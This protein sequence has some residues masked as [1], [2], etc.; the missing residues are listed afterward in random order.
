MA[1]NAMVS[2]KY[3]TSGLTDCISLISG[4]DLC[5]AIKINHFLA[6]LCGVVLY[7]FIVFKNLILNRKE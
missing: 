7:G 3:E 5:K 2:L 6:A 1:F 4:K